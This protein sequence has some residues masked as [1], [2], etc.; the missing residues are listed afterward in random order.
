MTGEH[1]KLLVSTIQQLSLARDL[2]AII[3][4]VQRSARKLTAA[5]G[6]TFVL[7]DKDQCFYANEDAI[8]PLWKGQ[9]FPLEHCVSGWAMINR[10]S[11][12]IKD[13]YAD[14]RVPSEAYE[15]TFVKSLV[16]VPIRI[17]DPVGAIGNYWANEHESTKEEVELL[18]ALADITSVSMENIYVYNELEERVRQR[19]AELEY[20]NQELEA[21]S[22]SVS[23]DLQSPLR[24]INS[25][26]RMV[27]ENT[28][29]K[30]AD[31]ELN[32]LQAAG[33]SAMRMSALV[34]DLLELSKL[35]KKE[36]SKT[37]VDMNTLVKSVVD[38][39]E[40]DLKTEATILIH[41]LHEIKADYSLMRQ[42]MYNLISNAV[43]Y[44]S[45]NK[46]P[47]VEISS[48]QQDDEIIFTI[49]DNGVGFSMKYVKKLFVPFQR[50]HNKSEFEG[51]GIGL[52][53]V[54]RII[55]RHGGKIWAD[56][57]LNEGATFYFSLKNGIN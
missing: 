54:S 41:P 32:M 13:I 11:V 16:I 2:D 15:P 21:F 40:R 49:Q 44:S 9:R 42:A 36:I 34:D 31:G 23:H 7:K 19:T 1:L 46:H 20:L 18:Q 43:K 35:D 3:E 27:T 33:K 25:L 30:L 14:S 48:H 56:A 55:Q 37:R 38:D 24:S 28:D 53:N 52:A 29:G 4:I 50:L 8:A 51:S 22:Y 57:K 5:E 17:M 39:I 6:V 12:V 26:I 10:S 47:R 45:K